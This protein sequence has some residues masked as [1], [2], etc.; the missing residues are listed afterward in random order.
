MI[1]DGK[2]TVVQAQTGSGKTLVYSL[3]ILAKVDASRASIQAVIV[4]PT[5][6]LGLQV[7]AV[8]KQLSHGSPEK[9]LVMTVIEGSNNRRYTVYSYTLYLVTIISYTECFMI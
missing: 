9:I 1:L 5:R 2:D 8:L 3:P 6:E 7:A 4:V